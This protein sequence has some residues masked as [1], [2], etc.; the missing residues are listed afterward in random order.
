ML[1]YNNNCRQEQQ[2]DV[3]EPAEKQAENSNNGEPFVKVEWFKGTLSFWQVSTHI[4]FK[5]S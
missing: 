2:G 5:L 1:I 4:L 3:K